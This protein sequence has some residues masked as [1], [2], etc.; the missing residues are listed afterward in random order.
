MVEV[1]QSPFIS[2]SAL[3]SRTSATAA[4]VASFSSAMSTISKG[5]RETFTEAAAFSILSLGPTRIPP[6]MSSCWALAMASSASGSW[7]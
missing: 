7:A 6:A 3:P 5:A 4:R 1:L 2:T